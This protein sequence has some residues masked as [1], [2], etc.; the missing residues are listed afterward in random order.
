MMTKENA[1]EKRINNK[2]K[3]FVYKHSKTVKA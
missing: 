3:N 2:I 1:E